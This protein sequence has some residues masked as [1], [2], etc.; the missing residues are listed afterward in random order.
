VVALLAHL[1]PRLR[2]GVVTNGLRATQ[3]EKLMACQLIGCIDFLLTSEEARVKKPDP[4]LF[5]LALEQAQIRRDA[6]VVVGDSWTL[7]V[8]GAQQAGIRSIWLNRRQEPCPDPRLTT[9]L[10]A[11]EPLEH[12]LQVLEAP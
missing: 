11:F 12:T 9:E 7:D 3:R 8:L 5:L 2:I 4:R 10:T 6:A 1:H